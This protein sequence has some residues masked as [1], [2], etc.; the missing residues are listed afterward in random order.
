[1]DRGAGKA[2]G[3]N[4]GLGDSEKG[5][6]EFPRYESLLYIRQRPIDSG[7]CNWSKVFLPDRQKI[8]P[9]DLA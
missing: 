3:R 2:G 8:E 1:M 4:S 9:F 6:E 7:M 5:Y